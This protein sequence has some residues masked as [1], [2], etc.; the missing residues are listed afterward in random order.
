[1]NTVGS[2]RDAGAQD[3]RRRVRDPVP[4][5]GRRFPVRDRR[6]R[7]PGAA[8][9]DVSRALRRDFAARPADLRARRRRRRDPPS[10]TRAGSRR[11]SLAGRTG[12]AGVAPEVPC[13]HARGRHAQ[14]RRLPRLHRQLREVCRASAFSPDG[15]ARTANRRCAASRIRS[16]GKSISRTSR[17][18]PTTGRRTCVTT[19]SRTRT[20][21]SSPRSMRCSERRRC[22]WSCRCTRSRC[23]TFV[24]PDRDSTMGRSRLRRSTASGWRRISIRCRSGIRRLKARIADMP[25]AFPHVRSPRIIRCTRSRSGR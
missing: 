19:D 16:S 17:S 18:S 22:R 24:L 8:R 23:R 11:A 15:V 6:L 4:G 1:M 20:I 7:R 9:H 14:V 5:G 12:R 2:A 10:D 13:I 25:A 21:S 3:E